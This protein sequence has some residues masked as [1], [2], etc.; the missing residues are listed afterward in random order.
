MYV[1]RPMYTY[2]DYRTIKDY[3]LQFYIA[4]LIK[5]QYFIS[6]FRVTTVLENGVKQ[7]CHQF[8]IDG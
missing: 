1:C 4:E 6:C 8:W 3:T 5:K 7:M 2:F